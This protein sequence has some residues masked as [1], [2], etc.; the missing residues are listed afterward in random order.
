MGG[1]LIR[2]KWCR[3]GEALLTQSC[4]KELVSKILDLMLQRSRFTGMTN[5]F[6]A[7]GNIRRMMSFSK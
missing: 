7:S 6:K 2:S 3:T 1:G 4:A 5:V